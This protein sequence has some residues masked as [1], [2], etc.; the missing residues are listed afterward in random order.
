MILDHFEFNI[1]DRVS[2][3]A[4][5]EL[6]ES[7]LY[8]THCRLVIISTVDPLYFLSEEAPSV[9][10]DGKDPEESRRLLDRWA[11]VLSKFTKVNLAPEGP[12]AL[13]GKAGQM[14]M[15]GPEQ[16]RFAEWTSVECGA[17]AF[18]RNLGVRILDEFQC[19][20]PATREE[21]LE[22]VL[23]RAGAFY[24][25]LWSGLTGAERL[26][27]YQLALDGWANPKNAA[28]I[29]QLERKQL[30]R[31]APMYCII[32]SSLRRFVQS[33]EHTEEIAEWEK[34]EQQS[35][36]RA[37][38]FAIIA[39]VIGAGVWL[40]Y[41]QAQLFQIGTGYITAIAALLTALAGFSA[42]LKRPTPQQSEAL[43]ES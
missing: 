10:S 22:I 43:T 8:G 21:L 29:Q 30:I 1:R 34:H 9:L 14:A 20:P 13:S 12:D 39:A 3:L 37:L 31:R 25:V 18:L 35:T 36:W 38:R 19:R 15:L 27:L 11:R 40:L 23:D 17:T 2:N 42:R 33:T 41:T 24:H 7:L 32:N 26:V 4:R 28:A 16:A 6:L 5:L